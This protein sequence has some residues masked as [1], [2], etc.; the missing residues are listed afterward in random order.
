[1]HSVAAVALVARSFSPTRCRVASDVRHMRG[2]VLCCRQPGER[3]G[4]GPR[5]LENVW[6]AKSSDIHMLMLQNSRI[7]DMPLGLRHR[8]S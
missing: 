1:M 5:S 2:L 4:V 7:M 6:Q 3:L 8:R